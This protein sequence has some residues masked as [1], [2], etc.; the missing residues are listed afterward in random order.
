MNNKKK[1]IKERVGLTILLKCDGISGYKLIEIDN[2]NFYSD[3]E[4]ECSFLKERMK[5]NIFTNDTKTIISRY[6]DQVN[7]VFKNAEIKM[8]PQDI[9]GKN[10]IFRGNTNL[11]KFV[12]G[13]KV[14]AYRFYSEEKSCL[15]LVEEIFENVKNMIDNKCWD[16]KDLEKLI[17]LEVK[18][19]HKNETFKFENIFKKYGVVS[20]DKEYVTD[21]IL[22]T[23]KN[24]FILYKRAFKPN[25]ECKCKAI[26]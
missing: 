11:I 8:M 22:N 5:N 6:I 17:D 1:N 4:R 19:I 26:Y 7:K 15:A 16:Y 2:N 3:I 14:I 13:K 25:Y 12:I 18:T 20:L 23:N 9:A 24:R 10:N 21:R